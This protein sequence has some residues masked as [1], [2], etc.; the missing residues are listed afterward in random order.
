MDVVIIGGGAT[1]AG[2][3]LD[4]A[5]R[6]LRCL[7][8][9]QEDYAWGTSSRSTKLIHGGLRYL[10]QLEISLVKEVGRERAILHANAP[11]LVHPEELL[12]PIIESGSLGKYT[13]P[14]GLW[15]YEKLAGVPKDERFHTL[16]K[17]EALR[18]EPLLNQKIVKAGAIYREYRTDDARLVTSLLKTA[19]EMGGQSLNYARVEDF[20]YSDDGAITGVRILDRIGKTSYEIRAKAVVNAAGPWCDEVRKLD[21]PVQGKHLQL[22]KGVHLVFSRERFPLERSVYFDVPSD[23]RMV[24]AVRRGET[25]YLGTTDTLYQQDIGRPRTLS[26]DAQYLLAAANFM[27][28]MLQLQP[29]D[30][31]SSWAGLRPLIHEEGKDPSEL[32]RKDEVFQTNSGLISIA[33]GKLTGYRMMAYRVMDMVMARLTTQSGGHYKDSSTEHLVLKGG[34]FANYQ[35][36]GLY[37]HQLLGEARQIELVPREVSHLVDCYGTEA[38]AIL[39]IAYRLHLQETNPRNRILRAE[40]EYTIEQEG[41]CSLSDFL[42]RRSGRLYFD[43]PSLEGMYL[44]VADWIAEKLEISAEKKQLQIAAF[45]EAY[46]EVIS[47]PEQEEILVSH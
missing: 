40:L 3:L 10:K 18:A 38:S 31:Q 9:E 37:K 43:R 32:S 16:N 15:M 14:V 36:V 27:F 8:L 6:G 41:V 33:G 30:I 19:S 47:F 44:L 46:F 22:T 4:A 24:F 25:T 42:I 1:G 26:D 13:T 39:E 29:A 20:L 35:A 45:E 34:D 23:G 2:I 12:L 17:E 28:P 5:S 7:L 21:G 11:H